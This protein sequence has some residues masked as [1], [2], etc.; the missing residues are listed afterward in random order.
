MEGHKRE[1]QTVTKPDGPGQHRDRY[2][3]TRKDPG[4]IWQQVLPQLACLGAKI[5]Q[6]LR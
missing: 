1:I 4:I 2:P 5:S 6:G 3:G